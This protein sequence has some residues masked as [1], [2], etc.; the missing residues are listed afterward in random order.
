MIYGAAAVTLVGC[1]AGCFFS[2][3]TPPN[4]KKIPRLSRADLLL[5]L[6]F[7]V[8]FALLAFF[9]LGDRKAPATGYDIAGN[10]VHLTFSE[11]IPVEGL[12]L[13]PALNERNGTSD[14]VIGWT[15]AGG[16]YREKRIRSYSVFTWRYADL[17]STAREITVYSD[18]KTLTLFE[19]GI[20]TPDGPLGADPEFPLFD[21]QH[22]LPERSTCQN[23]AYFDEIYHARTAYEYV[24]GLPA[25]E[26]THP[27]L[28]KAII[29]LGIRLFGMTP[30]GWRCMS[31]AAGT[32]VIAAV[33]VFA[34]LLTGSILGAVTASALMGLDF[35]HLVQSR[36]GTVDVFLTLFM[37]LSLLFLYLWI[38]N[39]DGIPPPR[40]AALSALFFGMAVSVKWSAAY[41]APAIA[42]IAAAR[43]FSPEV[44]ASPRQKLRTLCGTAA[45]F[46]AVGLSVYVLSYIPFVAADGSRGFS[47]ILKN[48]ADI[49]AYHGGRMTG[50]QLLGSSPFYTW[51]LTL[52]PVRYYGTAWSETERAAISAMGN[53]LVFWG[54]L[55]AMA[56][57]SY[58]A[59]R[60]R[61]RQ[62]AFLLLSYLS[63]LLPW[64]LVQRDTFLYH[65]YP[66]VPLLALASAQMVSG[67]CR[68][69]PRTAY[70]LSGICIAAAAVLLFLFYPVLTG[71]PLETRTAEPVLNWF[72]SWQL[73]S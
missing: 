20:L 48:Q 53:P 71:R 27:P 8:L 14:I 37:L 57:A 22:T 13:Y 7:C 38:Q 54:G 66:C 61:D 18:A 47:A 32:A 11:S 72:S 3:S 56:A 42:L 17:N 5:L 43:I 44:Q 31:A 46:A 51:P 49:L 70:L 1:L 59:I 40:M 30:F 23:S 16:Q 21:E 60:R 24:H 55:C 69:R 9:S 15:D 73:L 19:I 33:Y 52:F 25:Y 63:C 26:W 45:L 39:R 34:R 29:S 12:W 35:L 50:A 6:L 41:L 58:T 36:I 68:K 10:G 65:Y 67:L 4:R 28:G 64:M 2:R 62:C